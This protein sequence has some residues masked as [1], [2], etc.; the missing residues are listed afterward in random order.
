M[1]PYSCQLD[2]LNISYIMFQLVNWFYMMCKDLP[3]TPIPNAQFQLLKLKCSRAKKSL[4]KSITATG[5]GKATKTKLL[6][7]KYLSL[8]KKLNT[9]TSVIN[10]SG[11]LYIL[12]VKNQ[13]EMPSLS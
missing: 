2:Y 9:A 3:D 11:K 13:K 1:R 7:R 10:K 5:G 6:R 12:L 8:K 4:D